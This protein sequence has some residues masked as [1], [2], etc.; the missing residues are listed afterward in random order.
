MSFTSTSRTT[1]TIRNTGNYFRS[2][3]INDN[4]GELNI[5]GGG[6]IMSKDFRKA[7]LKKPV[8]ISADTVRGDGYLLKLKSAYTVQKVSELV[9]KIKENRE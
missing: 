2:A 8:L 3:L 1:T 6:I 4:W 9:Y 5:T 7:W